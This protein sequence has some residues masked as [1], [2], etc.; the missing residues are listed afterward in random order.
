MNKKH[1]KNM[2]TEKFAMGWAVLIVSGLIKNETAKLQ[3]A[4]VKRG[5]HKLAPKTYALSCIRGQTGMEKLVSELRALGTKETSF[6]AMYV[7]RSQWERSYMVH[8]L[9]A[10]PAPEDENA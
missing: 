1:R 2:D 6:R 10:E 7:T 4:I 3:R 5:A 9:S 8:G